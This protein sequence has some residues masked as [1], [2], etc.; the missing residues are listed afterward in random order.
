[1]K[2][3]RATIRRNAKKERRRRAISAEEHR[4]ASPVDRR[5]K[6]LKEV[7]VEVANLRVVA[8]YLIKAERSPLII[9]TE[10]DFVAGAKSSVGGLLKS[11]FT[12]REH[13]V[14]DKLQVKSLETFIEKID[15]ATSAHELNEA[16]SFFNRNSCILKLPAKN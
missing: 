11:L 16:F 7:D 10:R 2:P 15:S 8:E 13:L 6:F 4:R 14:L 1:M 5:I 12:N 3:S 9:R